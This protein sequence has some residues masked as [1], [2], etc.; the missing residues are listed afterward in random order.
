MLGVQF[1]EVTLV[2]PDGWSIADELTRAVAGVQTDAQFR[3]LQE[4]D[5]LLTGEFCLLPLHFVY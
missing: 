3:P 5:I 2:L 4:A 1:S